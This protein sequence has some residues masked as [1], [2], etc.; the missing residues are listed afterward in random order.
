MDNLILAINVVFPLLFMM[1]VGYILRIENF[2]NENSLNVMNKLIFV[3]FMPVLLFVNIYQMDIGEVLEENNLFLILLLYIIIIAVFVALIF[4]L[5]RFVKDKKKC[6]VMIQGLTRGN[7]LLFGIPI[8]ASIYGNDHTG[9]VS[10][11]AAFLIPL[12]NVLAVIVLELFRGGK[13]NVNK[14]LLGVVKNPI[15]IGSALAFI[16]VITGLKIPNLIMS[17]ID[18]M[19]KVTTPLSFVVLGGTFNFNRLHNN[20]KYLTTVVVGK[21]IIIPAVVF[22]IA[23]TLKLGN[24]YMAAILGIMTSPVAIA[25]FTMA[26]EMDADGELAGQIVITTSVV[27]IVTIFAWVYLLRTFNMI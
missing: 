13:V 24:E 20:A 3:V 18:S 17:P 27:S 16:F 2:V 6:S 10:L 12:F 15:I 21:L 8:V 22:L 25:S 19:S 7:S 14:V 23:C 5:P 26:K 1:I 4:I 11:L 9:T